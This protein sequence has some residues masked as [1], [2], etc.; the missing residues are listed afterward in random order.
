MTIGEDKKEGSVTV[1]FQDPRCSSCLVGNVDLEFG[2]FLLLV[3]SI[4]R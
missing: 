2:T 3:I 4:N 1:E